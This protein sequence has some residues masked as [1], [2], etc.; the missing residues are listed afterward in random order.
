MKSQTSTV[1]QLRAYIGENL[2]NVQIENLQKEIEEARE[3]MANL[4]QENERLRSTVE[5]LNVRLSSMNEILLIQ[6][7][8]LLKFQSKF[9]R[10]PGDQENSLLTKWREKVF[11]L[12]VQLK[13]QQ[14]LHE[15][16]ERSG[17]AQVGIS[18]FL[19]RIYSEV[20]SNPW[21]VDS[22]IM[23]C[24]GCLCS[25]ELS[26]QCDVVLIAG[27]WPSCQVLFCILVE[28]DGVKV[29]RNVHKS[30]ARPISSYLGQ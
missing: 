25:I 30:K 10:D 1:D 29:D 24:E 3:H 16:E 17:H 23:E 2:P 7:S 19:N 15:K 20:L 27:L 9:V 6:E 28:G 22:R 26:K 13:S 18:V 8:E 14:I 12:L 21:F 4:L 5:L 11:A